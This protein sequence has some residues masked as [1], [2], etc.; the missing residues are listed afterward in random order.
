[1]TKFSISLAALLL[2]ISGFIAAGC[3]NSRSSDY[4]VR[5]VVLSVSEKS[6]DLLHEAIHNFRN[7]EGETVGMDV[8]AMTFGVRDNVSVNNIT[9]GDKVY[10]KFNVNWSRNPRLMIT[11]IRALEPDVKLQLDG[12]AIE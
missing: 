1:M 5:G 4:E 9:A 3:G 11:S 8:M 10:V 6:I 2:L 7:Q 12:Y